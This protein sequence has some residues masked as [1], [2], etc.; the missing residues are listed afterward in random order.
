MCVLIRAEKTGGGALSTA[1]LQG[2]ERVLARDGEGRVCGRNPKS[3]SELNRIRSVAGVA[4][5][6]WKH[7]YCIRNE[8]IHIYVLCVYV[9][10]LTYLGAAVAEGNMI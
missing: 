3:G 1:G 2:C 7:I 9:C 8:I 10:A 5:S 6:P 4:D